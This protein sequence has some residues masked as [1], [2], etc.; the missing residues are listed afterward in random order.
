MKT[1]F[2][3]RIN[4]YGLRLPFVF[5]LLLCLLL[6]PD[7]ATAQLGKERARSVALEMLQHVKPKSKVTKVDLRETYLPEEFRVHAFNLPEKQGFVLVS[8]IEGLRSQILAYSPDGRIDYAS[9]SPALK[10]YL[11][12]ASFLDPQK[13]KN[14]VQ[15]TYT[16]IEPMIPYK[17]DQLE[18]Y[19]RRAPEVGGKHSYTGCG[20]TALA[21]LIAYNRYP[22]RAIGRVNYTSN[23]HD[24]HIVEDLSTISFDF[25][26]MREVYTKGNYTDVEAKAV[27]DLMYACGIAMKMNYSPYG[28]GSG[29]Y[30][31]DLLYAV[32]NN[33]L[34]DTEIVGRE[35]YTDENW[36]KMLHEEFK[37]NRPVL[38]LA[39]SKRHGGHFFL[40][41]GINES[42]FVHINWGWSGE[43]DGFFALDAFDPRFLYGDGYNFN[44]WVLKGMIPKEAPFIAAPISGSAIVL[45]TTSY[46]VELQVKVIR[47]DAW[48]DLNSSKEYDWNETLSLSDKRVEYSTEINSEVGLYGG[49]SELDCSENNFKTISA[50]RSSDLE[51]LNCSKNKISELDFSSCANV[52]YIDCHANKIKG[53]AMTRLI[54]SLPQR[55]EALRGELRLIDLDN[56]EEKNSCTD[57]DV[58]IATKK[59]WI[60]KVFKDGAW[61]NYEQSNPSDPTAVSPVTVRKIGDGEVT[62]QGF[63]D[64]NQVPHGTT[65]TV[66]VA[67]AEGWELAT[68]TANE[69]DIKEN[70]TFVVSG[71]TH[72]VA[73]FVQKTFVVTLR[74]NEHG[75]IAIAEKLP[76][77]KVPYGMTLTVVDFP[78]NDQCRLEK[79]TAN[80][81][82]IMPKRMAKIVADTEIVAEFVDYTALTDLSAAVF[83]VYPNPAGTYVEVFGAKPCEEVRILSLD[84]RCLFFSHTNE[85]GFVHIEFR[86]PNGNYLLSV[87]EKTAK[88]SIKN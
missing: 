69:E 24:L 2:L 25:D 13:Q 76:L 82:D 15:T 80:G 73:T 9:M 18:P 60:V 12:L 10:M 61:R 43:D 36:M 33:F 50:I 44:Q 58:A 68:L 49:I 17:W 59:N 30:M 35:K 62:I 71:P 7:M 27:S 34:Y 45:S 21:M 83:Q 23:E 6:L 37:A 75:T 47:N 51:V 66:V 46:S 77:D 28:A 31:S 48:I 63:D 16:P 52:K 85:N 53:E 67:P 32:K 56:N 86:L 70:K 29:A 42:G 3:H 22:E 64:L 11:E 20:A 1:S 55:S 14:K 5:S 81:V 65:L 26:N 54:N 41:D 39:Q 57:A 87:G 8:D 19:N 4:L 79:L 88:L 74:S 38:H 78:K 72:I 40:A 84:G